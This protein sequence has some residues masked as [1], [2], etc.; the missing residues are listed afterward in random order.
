MGHRVDRAWGCGGRVHRSLRHFVVFP[1]VGGRENSCQGLTL[2]VDSGEGA[3][4]PSSPLIRVDSAS[5]SGNFIS[6]GDQMLALFSST[7]F[8]A[9]LGFVYVIICLWL[10]LV[11]LLQ[12]GKSGGM[13]GMDS[14]SQAPEVL[15]GAFGSGGTQRGLFKITSW[16]AAIFFVIALALTYIGNN[17][18]QMGGRLLLDTELESR[19]SVPDATSELPELDFLIDEPVDEPAD[20]PVD[21]VPVP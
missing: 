19:P 21:P 1:Q 20:A 6:N 4:P 16:S 17:R 12:E 8:L 5:G 11:V 15:T 13:A 9:L 3:T 18:E 14:A 2:F 7:W 10:I